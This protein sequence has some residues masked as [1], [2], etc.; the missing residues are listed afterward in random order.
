MHPSGSFVGP[1]TDA[2]RDNEVRGLLAPIARLAEKYELA[3]LVVAHRR[4]SSGGSADDLALGS[5]AFTGIA[6]A[7]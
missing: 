2:P 3:V 4:K 1:R 6:R 5:R 7:V